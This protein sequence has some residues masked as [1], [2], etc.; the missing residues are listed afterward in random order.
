M[1]YQDKK[2]EL[3]GKFEEK[4]KLISDYQQKIRETSEELLRIQGE[5]RLIEELLKEEV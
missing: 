4:K 2:Q 3:E 1:N 5:Y